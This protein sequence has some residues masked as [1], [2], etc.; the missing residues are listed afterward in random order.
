MAKI[1]IKHTAY[2]FAMFF[3][4]GMLV[5][6][7]FEKETGVAK[8]GVGIVEEGTI[9]NIYAVA[10]EIGKMK[11][12]PL[13]N[14]WKERFA[15]AK[16]DENDGYY[17]GLSNPLKRSAGSLSITN[18]KCHPDSSKYGPRLRACE[19]KWRPVIDRNSE[20]GERRIKA[21]QMLRVE[22]EAERNRLK[23]NEL[24]ELR[25]NVVSRAHLSIGESEIVFSD[26]IDK[27]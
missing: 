16:D 11:L 13:D 15:A 25:S 24:S 1:T 6:S 19:E 5:H 8:A 10:D 7:L 23:A 12:V 17:S 20:I 14:Y 18:R 22:I 3:F 2:G 26:K 9:S 21:L 4:L 27:E